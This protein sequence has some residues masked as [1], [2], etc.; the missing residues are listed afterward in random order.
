MQSFD[1]LFNIGGNYSATING[2]TEA[3]GQFSASVEGAQ[4][5]VTRFAQG[6]AVLDLASNYAEK[7]SNTIGG[8]TEAGVSLD[9]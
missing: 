7:L 9:R 2:I 1:Y 5:K 3:T 8:F 6:L 4:G